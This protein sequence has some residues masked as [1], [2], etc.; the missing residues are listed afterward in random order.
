MSTNTSLKSVSAPLYNIPPWNDLR[1]P[2][3]STTSTGSNPP[4]AARIYRN[5]VSQGVYVNKFVADNTERELYFTIQL[6]HTYLQG[7]N[8]KPHLHFTT[9]DAITGTTRWGLEYTMSSI[10]SFFPTTTIIIEGTRSIG[11]GDANKHMILD[12]PE[13]VGTGLGISSILICRLFRYSFDILN[14][15][16]KDSYDAPIY[17]LE[18]DIHHQNDTAGSRMEFIK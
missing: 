14:P 3:M 7:S 4:V 5:N 10:N 13:I 8:L 9:L 6:P 12:F 2:L 16:T 1:T 15:L 11:V 18:C 17:A